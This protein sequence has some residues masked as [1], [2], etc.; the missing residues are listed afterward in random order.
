MPVRTCK[1]QEPSQLPAAKS[2]L[3]VARD[4]TTN[5]TKLS[6]Q[7]TDSWRKGLAPRI[8]LNKET[9]L[10][11][12]PRSDGVLSLFLASPRESV[13]SGELLE[14][15]IVYLKNNISFPIYQNKLKCLK[16]YLGQ[17]ISK[18]RK[19]SKMISWILR[20]GLGSTS[21]SQNLFA[22]AQ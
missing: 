20:L 13:P 18:L 2:P 4:C 22:I 12:Q 14:L 17:T 3:C 5:I 16:N 10:T 11:L 1:Q 6:N 9:Y 19:N 21:N 15:K 8:C 7:S